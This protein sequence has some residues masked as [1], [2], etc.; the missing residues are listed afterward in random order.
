MSLLHTSLPGELFVS[1][2]PFPC[3]KLYARDA[4]KTARLLTQAGRFPPPT[5]AFLALARRQ[6]ASS[7]AASSKATSSV[8]PRGFCPLVLVAL[9]HLSLSKSFPLLSPDLFR[10][11]FKNTC[12]CPMLSRCPYLRPLLQD[13][14]NH[15]GR[16]IELSSGVETTRP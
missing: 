1:R 11:S 12:P 15:R 4:G 13:S 16:G 3:R 7:E 2:Q 6:R 10:G 8:T 5:G 14:C 9:A